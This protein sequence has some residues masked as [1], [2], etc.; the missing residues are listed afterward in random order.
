MFGLTKD[1][2]GW[3]VLRDWELIKLLNPLISKYQLHRK[4]YAVS[5]E[6]F[7]ISNMKEAI[8]YFATTEYYTKLPFRVPDMESLVILSPGIELNSII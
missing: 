5:E 7:L 4:E 1:S 3:K 6:D 2:I 8:E